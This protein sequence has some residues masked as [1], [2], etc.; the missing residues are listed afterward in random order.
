MS[1]NRKLI[2]DI[3]SKKM[4]L[5]L[6]LGFASG[7]PLFVVLTLLGAF[8]RTEGVNLKEIGLFSLIMFPYTWK[9]IWA[10]LVDR[11]DL[12]K[13]GRRRSWMVVSQA[14]VFVCI[15]L[16]GQFSAQDH[17]LVIAAVSVLLS[18]SSATQD[19]VIDAYRREILSDRELGLGTSLFIT[20]SRASSLIPGGLS[21]ILAQFI[22][23]NEVFLITAAFMLPA[24]VISFFIKE[25][26]QSNAPRTLRQA[27]VEPF[28]EFVQRKGLG[29]MLLV[30]LFVFC[31][32]LGDSMAT[33]LA[34]PFYI[35][36]HYDLMTIGLV[37]KNAGLWSM[38]IG[39]IVGGIIML[40]TGINK[41]LWIF[42]FGQLITILG[43]VILARQ[44]VG[45][46]SS[47]SVWLLA[48]VIIAECLGAGLGTS[49]F[50]AFLSAKTNKNYA[51]TQFALLTSLSAVPRTFCNA[52][53]GYIVEFMGWENFFWF[54]TLLAVPGMLLLIKVAP[55]SENK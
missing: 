25:P 26:E 24:L 33:A 38:I 41:A 52:T 13:L 36:M 20:A 17:L 30:I 4:L 15:F 51:A 46:D 35:D 14:T 27:V 48:A 8:L 16:I 50:V 45:Q 10:P 31:Y 1:A 9:F 22:S 12:I 37:A 28:R 43:F 47:P 3:F 2:R 32:K 39:G 34:T 18:F 21:L 5:C 54:C 44:G 42:G 23:W 40:K 55:Y 29:S 53:T 11:Y 6:S 19:I 7:M 49:A